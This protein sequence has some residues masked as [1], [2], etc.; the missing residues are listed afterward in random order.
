MVRLLLVADVDPLRVIGGGERLLAGH[1][2]ALHARGHE[3]TVCSGAPGEALQ[4]RSFAVERMGR[5]PATPRRAW[6]AVRRLRPDVV[7]GYQPACASGALR[8]ARRTGIGTVYVFCSSW[9]AEY[10]T[11]RTRPRA[12]GVAARLA[13]ER[14][15]LRASDRVVVLSEYSA[16]Q[17]AA[18]HPALPATI[19]VVPGGVDP[20]RFAPNGSPMAA[21]KRLGLPADGPLLVTVRNL[22]PRMGLDGL[23]DAMP[24]V[25][26]RYPAARLVVVGEGPLRGSLEARARLLG[27]AGSV[28]FTGY[29]PEQHLP[30]H[31]RAA[32]LALLPTRTLE[33]FGLTTVEALACGT[34]V[35]G[36]PVGAIPEILRPLDTA[37][38]TC[39]ATPAGI[40]AGIVRFL[41]SPP[42]AIDR[43]ARRHVLEGYTWEVVGERLEKVL[44]EVAR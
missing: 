28:V 8:A 35:L 15:C 32:D 4:G 6:A 20:S 44:A 1:A 19:H 42:P 40:G 37:C 41:G 14:A 2:A 11:R 21:R 25:R 5:A 23:L 16:G 33:S 27:L 22:V 24:I 31:Y 29:V 30:D 10:A 3:V 36:T 43:R 9:P 13:L 39:D 7:L 38:V 12:A 34:P 26:K 17:V 18:A